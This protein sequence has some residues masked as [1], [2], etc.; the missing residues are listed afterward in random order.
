MQRNEILQSLNI[1]QIRYHMFD[2][3]HLEECTHHHFNLFLFDL[4]P[5]L[6]LYLNE[7][8]IHIL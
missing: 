1:Q 2:S 8:K 4:F 3:T 5:T 6:N 7:I